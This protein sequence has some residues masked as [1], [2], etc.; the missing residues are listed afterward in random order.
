MAA[1]LGVTLILVALA[2]LSVAK[3]SVRETVPA[4]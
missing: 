1:G 3:A 4:D 2:L